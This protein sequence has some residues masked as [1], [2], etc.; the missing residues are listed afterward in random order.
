M[1]RALD[2]AEA[3]SGLFL[4]AILNGHQ[5]A[6]GSQLGSN[7]SQSDKPRSSRPGQSGVIEDP[8]RSGGDGKIPNCLLI[9]K[10]WNYMVRSYRP[11]AE[12][13]NGG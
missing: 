4:S 10:R 11:H 6:R 7:Q 2:P 3:A 1:R 9:V 12:I 13:S 5:S 8:G